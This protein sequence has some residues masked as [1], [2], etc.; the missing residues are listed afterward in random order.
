MI[1]VIGLVIFTSCA[2]SKKLMINGKET[3]V[4]PYGWANKDVKKVEGVK[5]QVC[6][7]NVV[8]IVI[9]AE[10]VIVPVWLTGWE[11]LEPVSVE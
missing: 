9:G 3:I 7:G 4:E 6:F 8:W 11:L 10:T 2:D 5:Y 1:L